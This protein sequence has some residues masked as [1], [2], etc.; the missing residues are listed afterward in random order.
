[1][2]DKSFQICTRC[3]MDTTDPAITF[4]EQGG[5][6]HCREFDR[7]TRKNWFP[8]EEGAK[9][10]KKIIER[11][12]SESR[13]QKYDCIL[14]ISG[15]ADSS[16]LALKVKESGLRPLVVHVDGG[17]NSELAV[18]NI[19]SIV[20]YC[21]FDLHTHVMYWDDMKKLQLAYLRAGVANQDVPQDH[22]FFANLYD[23]AVKN[24]IKYV[25]SGGNIATEAIF[26]KAWQ[27]SAM[28]AT[29]LKAIFERFGNG[30]LQ[31]FKTVSFFEYYLYYPFIWRMKVVYIL[32]YIPYN[33][34]KAIQE[35]QEKTEWRPYGYKHNESVFTRFFQNYYLI[36][37]FGYDKR[38]PHLS[39]LI[40]TGQ[41]TRQEALSELSKPAY[42]DAEVEK[43]ILYFCKKLSLDREEFDRLMNMPPRN[44]L[45]FPSD[46][47]KYLLMKKIQRSLE[48]MFNKR[49]AKYS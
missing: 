46:Q 38:K 41:L 48:K 16:Y 11:I 22:A 49:L 42:D 1:M 34:E 43:D 27:H 8:N 17:W 7:I 37:R 23:F 15:G 36:K 10:L 19:E 39:S 28:D 47:N 18:K 20:R 5:C 14:G 12:Q 6:S 45:E 3:V 21:G 44:A 33:R 4:D 26:P 2:N 13:G 40:I 24:N 32:N 31:E 30:K 25:L 29:N 9:Q 35:L